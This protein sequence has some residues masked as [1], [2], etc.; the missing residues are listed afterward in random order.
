MEKQFIRGY[1]KKSAEGKLVIIA[2]DE[3]LDRH[4]EVLKLDSWDLT[5]FN[6]APRLLVDHDHRVENIVGKAENTQVDRSIGALTFEPVFHDITAK[7]REVKEMVE[8]GFLDT[9][10]VGFIPHG[11]EKDGGLPRN[12]LIEISFVT[13]GANPSARVKAFQEKMKELVVSDEEK[14]KIEEFASVKIQA[15]NK[16]FDSSEKVATLETENATLKTSLGESQQEVKRLNAHC[17]KLQT[18]L[19]TK[20]KKTLQ[21]NASKAVLKEV[22]RVINQSLYTLNKS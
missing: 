2:S 1:F 9:V 15:C 11:P 18:A 19:T 14:G 7:A 6:K 16:C 10:S 22:A 4:G 12:E 3:T 21:D 17:E 8:Q 20:N 5:E 13:V